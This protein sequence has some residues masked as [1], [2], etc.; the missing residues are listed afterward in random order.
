MKSVYKYGS[1]SVQSLMKIGPDKTIEEN[2][3]RIPD[4]NVRYTVTH[5]GDFYLSN[6][7]IEETFKA[8]SPNPS[9]NSYPL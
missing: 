5:I 1:L 9:S 7:G 4:N 3:A 8:K 2:V 6:N